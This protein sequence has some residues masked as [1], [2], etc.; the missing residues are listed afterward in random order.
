MTF[1]LTKGIERDGF[2]YGYFLNES[3]VFE[4]LLFL[5]SPYWARFRWD[6]FEKMRPDMAKD[7][8]ISSVREITLGRMED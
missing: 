2:E 1:Y 3:P 6:L 8:D 5:I 4:G 7:M